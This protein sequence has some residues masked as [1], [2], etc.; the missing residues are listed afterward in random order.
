MLKMS[1]LH[2]EVWSR[3]L[4]WRARLPH[5]LLISGVKGLGKTDLAMEFSASLLCEALKADGA[6]CGQCPACQWFLKGNHPDFRVLTPAALA[7]AAE[8]TDKK[9]KETDAEAEEKKSN[10]K[11]QDIPIDEVR[12][13]DDFLSVGTHRQ[14]LRV[15]LICP[16]EALNQN[17]ANAL[18]KSL[19]E[20]PPDTLFLLISHEPMRLLPTLRSRCQNLPVPLPSIAR[21]ERFLA[22]KGVKEAASWL[23]LAGGA[24]KRALAL[25]ENCA[26]WFGEFLECLQQGER[27]EVLDAAARLEKSLKAVK[28]ENPLPQLV[29]WAQKWTLDLSLSAQGASVR[30]YYAQRAKITTLAEKCQTILLSRFDRYLLRQKQVSAHTLNT[31]LFLEQLLFEYRALFMAQ[32]PRLE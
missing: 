11:G 8:K 28:G 23:A 32:S 13:L 29:E 14:K 12:A 6:A 7:P 9:A 18:L 21:G 10:R 25:A 24:P 3:L 27:L 22:E 26:A 5:A 31:R 15:I 2:S 17:A 4:A 20:P 16:A 19:E 30:F 1:E